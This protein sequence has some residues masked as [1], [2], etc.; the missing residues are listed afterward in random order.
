MAIGRELRDKY[1]GR[2]DEAI[3]RAIRAEIDG[4]EWC[5]DALRLAHQLASRYIPGTDRHRDAQTALDALRRIAD[6]MEEDV[7]RRYGMPPRND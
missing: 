7:R 1:G 2:N 6:H 4:G 3:R 5:L